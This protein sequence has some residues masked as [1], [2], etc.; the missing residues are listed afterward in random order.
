M[1]DE[2]EVEHIRLGFHSEAE[3]GTGQGGRAG[4]SLQEEPWRPD[5]PVGGESKELVRTPSLPEPSRKASLH[6]RLCGSLTLLS[7][8]SSRPSLRR[9]PSSELQ[10]SQDRGTGSPWSEVGHFWL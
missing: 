5:C 9:G 7:T 8:A 10:G 6:L 1:W 2:V 3:E 4:P